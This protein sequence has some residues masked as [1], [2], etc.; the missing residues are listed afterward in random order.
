MEEG[1]EEENEVCGGGEGECGV[2]GRM[3][4]AIL[5][6]FFFSFDQCL[7]VGEILMDSLVVVLN[8]ID[9]IPE[10]QRGEE[11]E[12]DE[13]EGQRDRG[14]GGRGGREREREREFVSHFVSR[15][16]SHLIFVFLPASRLEKLEANIRKTL[17][18]SKFRD[19]QMIPVAANPRDS[20]SSNLDVSFCSTFDFLPLSFSHFLTLLSSCILFMVSFRRR[21]C[22]IFWRTS[23]SQIAF[24]RPRLILF[25]SQPITVS[26]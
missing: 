4:R 8:K 19:C 1:N 12:E 25:G 18:T 2:V 9:L 24:T 16:F 23:K 3:E 10:A 26:P 22:N 7:V 14:R 15:F 17:Q 20:S 11:Q 13:R 5:T 21:W 6:C